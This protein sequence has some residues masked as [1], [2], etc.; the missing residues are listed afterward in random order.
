[1]SP[2]L[3]K[4]LQIISKICHILSIF[5]SHLYLEIYLIF[6]RK[7]L[8]KA[9]TLELNHPNS[10]AVRFEKEFLFE[11][12]KLHYLQYRTLVLFDGYELLE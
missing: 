8:K 11:I 12:I 7:P 2:V 4:P 10:D 1:M 3:S 5:I 9:N 6:V